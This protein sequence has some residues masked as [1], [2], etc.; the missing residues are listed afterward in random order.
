MNKSTKNPMVKTDYDV[1]IKGETIDLC[2]PSDDKWVLDQWFRWFNRDEI[3]TYLAQ[4]IYPNTL[5]SQKAFYDTLV[6]ND[7][8]IVL[9]IKPKE[10]DGFI[11][12]ASL[13]SINLVHRRCDFSMVIGERLN[14]TGSLFY[15]LEAKALLTQHAIEK[16]GLERVNSSQILDLVRWQNWQILFG[17]Q[18][19]GISRKKFRKGDKVYDVLL[20][21][22]LLED[23]QSL[24]NMRNGSLWPGKSK[25]FQL[26]KDLPKKTLIED[27][28][29]LL[30]EKQK[31]YWNEV[32]KKEINGAI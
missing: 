11:G 32:F 13:S 30:P 10:Y 14:T 3:T 19:E 18:I 21:A 9:L 25:M 1:F 6:N 24:I 8:R 22:C 20:S 31:H 23:Y 15:G 4:G 28:S 5:K 2:V 29:I 12:V 27:L 26:L 17:Y 7:S 16:V